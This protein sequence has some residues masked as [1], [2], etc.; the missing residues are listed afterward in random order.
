MSAK[1]YVVV[2]A[3]SA[4]EQLVSGSIWFDDLSI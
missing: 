1:I 3:R 2:A 4:S